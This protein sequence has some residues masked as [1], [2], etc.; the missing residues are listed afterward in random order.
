VQVSSSSSE[1]GNSDH[2]EECMVTAIKELQLGGEETTEARIPL[3]ALQGESCPETF[4]LE[5]K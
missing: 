3:N 5:G 1:E 2:E 4:K